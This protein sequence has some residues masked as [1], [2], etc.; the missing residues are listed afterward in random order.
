MCAQSFGGFDAL[1]NAVGVAGVLYIRQPAACQLVASQ[2]RII[3]AEVAV[4]GS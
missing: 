4:L 2:D 1:G 3:A